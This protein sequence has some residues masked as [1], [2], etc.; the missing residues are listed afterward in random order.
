MSGEGMLFIIIACSTIIGFII[1]LI[2]DSKETIQEK[3]RMYDACPVRKMFPNNYIEKL[4]ETNDV[5]LVDIV[6]FIN[7]RL[8]YDINTKIYF[9]IDNLDCFLGYYTGLKVEGIYVKCDILRNEIYRN[10]NEAIAKH[11]DE[12]LV[13]LGKSKMKVNN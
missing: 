3:K 8:N 10:L 2:K 4:L 9:R 7:P 12:Y 11:N 5:E 6:G 1:I 13:E